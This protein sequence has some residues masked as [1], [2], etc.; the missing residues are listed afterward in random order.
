MI[1][2]NKKYLQYI[3]M[4]VITLLT[5]ISP[6]KIKAQEQSG[7]FIMSSVGF[8]P[9]FSN[10]SMSLNYAST[11]NCFNVQNGIAVL[12]GE[13]GIGLFTNNCVLD[14]KFN[15]LGIRLFPNPVITTT[16]V[17][18]INTPPLNDEFLISIWTLDGIKL[19]SSKA[20]G[21]EILK[22]K[23]LDYGSLVAGAYIIKIESSKYSDALKFIKVN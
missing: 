1:L 13:R 7:A 17:K 22:G 11:S 4:S 8:I 3:L 9:N 20:F 14:T 18:F 19:G 5:C 6:K 23:Q 21:F 15:T 12:T 10:N 16:M 2:S